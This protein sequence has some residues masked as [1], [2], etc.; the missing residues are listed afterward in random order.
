MDDK[1]EKRKYKIL[2]IEHSGRKGIR[3][4]PVKDPKY[5]GLIGSIIETENIENV[6]LF[7]EIKWDFVE[8][9]PAWYDLWHTS[10]VIEIYLDFEN[11]YVIETV[12]TIYILEKV[13]G[14]S[15]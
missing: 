10:P 12:N 8:N 1:R 13:F 9:K 2:N 14:E 5:D 7:N 4:E 3:Y 11:H 6:K 15:L